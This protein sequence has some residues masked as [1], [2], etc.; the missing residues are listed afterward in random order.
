MANYAF[1]H[2]PGDTADQNT[3]GNGGRRPQR[4]AVFRPG[5]RFRNGN[6]GRAGGGNVSLGRGRRF[7]P[8]RDANANLQVERL[9]TEVNNC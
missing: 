2:K 9:H 3:Q 6:D 5:R 1:A 7:R 8:E 4:D